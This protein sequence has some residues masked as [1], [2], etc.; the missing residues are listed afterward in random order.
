MEC[1]NA[2]SL[3]RKSGQWGTQH[4]LPVRQAGRQASGLN[5]VIPRRPLAWGKLRE[6]QHCKN[7]EGCEARRAGRQNFS[8]ARK[9]WELNSEDDLSAVGAALNLA[10]SR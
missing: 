8:P 2:T 3:H 6:E 4:S 5:V 7:R 10:G 1:I 9:G